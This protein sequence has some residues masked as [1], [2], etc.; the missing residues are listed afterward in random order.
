[1]GNWELGIPRS[2]LSSHVFCAHAIS[3]RGNMHAQEELA[4]AVANR[5]FSSSVID[6]L[7]VGLSLAVLSVPLLA[8]VRGGGFIR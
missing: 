3:K 7:Y 5:R 2:S 4:A 6:Y 8:Q 1:M